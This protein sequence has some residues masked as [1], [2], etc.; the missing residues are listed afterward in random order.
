MRDALRLGKTLTAM[1]KDEAEAF[2]VPVAK[3]R[4]YVRYDDAKPNLAPSE[5]AMW[6]QLV[7]VR[8]GNAT[9]RYPNGDNVQTV[10]PWKPPS[11]W[12]GV[13]KTAANEIL[14]A[15][16]AGPGEGERY[17]DYGNVKTERAAW[18]ARASARSQSAQRRTASR[19]HRQAAIAALQDRPDAPHAA[20]DRARCTHSE[21]LR[22]QRGDRPAPALESQAPALL[23]VQVATLGEG[24]FVSGMNIQRIATASNPTPV[25]LRNPAMG[26]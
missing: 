5:G 14:T 17:S 23:L 25:T 12:E 19:G 7:G 24:D 2:G 4:R 22:E 21:R 1:T 13:G 8:L 16:D 11:P 10:E 26:P 3:R 9:D 15:I 6:F 20:G 18:K